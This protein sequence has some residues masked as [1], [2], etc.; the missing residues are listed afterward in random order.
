MPKRWYCIIWSKHCLVHAYKR[1]STKMS[2]R[3]TYICI[4]VYT[5]HVYVH[6]NSC[7]YVVCWFFILR[8]IWGNRPISQI[9]QC[10]CPTS[11]NAPFRTEMCTSLFWMVH[12]G[13]RD[14]YIVGSV[15]LVC[16][17]PA[18]VLT[19][20]I[21]RSSSAMLWSTKHVLISLRISISLVRPE[22]QNKHECGY[23]SSIYQTSNNLSLIK[24]HVARRQIHLFL[25]T[26]QKYV[27]N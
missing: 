17:T 4:C 25:S 15:R 2:Y 3:A 20:R 27:F 1:H 7:S 18:D 19:P 22:S 12:C 13:R 24:Q 23:I 26:L 6:I 10:T 11:H 9:L 5:V 8:S 16:T 14:K 21:A